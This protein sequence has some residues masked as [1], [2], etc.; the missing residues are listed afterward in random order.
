MIIRLEPTNTEIPDEI[1]VRAWDFGND[2]F[3]KKLPAA[4]QALSEGVTIYVFRAVNNKNIV[5]VKIIKIKTASLVSTPHTGTDYPVSD[6]QI[7]L[8]FNGETWDIDKDKYLYG[9]IDW[10]GPANLQDNIVSSDQSDRIV[11]TWKGPPSRYFPIVDTSKPIAG[12]TYED[13]S[14]LSETIYTPFTS[15]L[16]ASGAVLAI[17]PPVNYP[18]S[19]STVDHQGQILGAAIDKDQVL[20][21]IVKAIYTE[22]EFWW[23]ITDGILPWDYYN[24]YQEAAVA[25]P[26]VPLSSKSIIQHDRPG[27]GYWYE[28]YKATGNPQ[29]VFKTQQDESG[30]EFVTR[31]QA[32]ERPKVPWFFN[33]SATEAQTVESGLVWKFSNNT[34][35]TKDTGNGQ[36]TATGS[37]KEETL[38]DT[39]SV[40]PDG[41][42]GTT[43]PGYHGKSFYAY[44]EFDPDY[45][46][47]IVPYQGKKLEGHSKN[48]EL[49]INKS[50]KRI[51]AVDYK[52]DKE[53]V[54][55]VD[56]VGSSLSQFS[57]I[58]YRSIMGDVQWADIYGPADH[59]PSGRIDYVY[60]DANSTKV[61]DWFKA[62]L[63]NMCRPN[64]TYT[65]SCGVISD[66][67]H[68]LNL[69]TCCAPCTKQL[70]V[71][72]VASSPEGSLNLS[73][74]QQVKMAGTWK[75]SSSVSFSPEGGATGVYLYPLKNGSLSQNNSD[76]AKERIKINSV[77][78]GNTR[79]NSPLCMIEGW[80][81]STYTVKG[82]FERLHY[83]GGNPP[84]I[85][86]CGGSSIASDCPCTGNGLVTGQQLFVNG[87]RVGFYAW[88]PYG[89][90]S[91]CG[92]GRTAYFF[93]C[94]YGNEFCTANVV[95]EYY[96]TDYV[97][98]CEV[99]SC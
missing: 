45:Q 24:T 22:R 97:C 8:G 63:F 75:T 68:I 87:N 3:I 54:A 50:G 30:W 56:I 71:N 36:W 70:V 89:A 91:S 7:A 34:F 40:P 55:T 98:T 82:T 28:V 42:F 18:K 80:H 81:G 23:T 94:G 35:T 44:D 74:T 51:V 37:Y 85:G 88:V 10:L 96:V 47:Y 12:I 38:N 48:G 26:D 93:T 11:L 57:S 73:N 76:C 41:G 99:W 84:A 31:I 17:G 72:V 9:N 69:D 62:V 16:Y 58:D 6:A 4:D 20:W 86:N 1:L 53:V 66:D 95:E 13:T 14:A 78:T 65:S 27:L 21:V 29:G 61:G 15:N 43:T 92:T 59:I 83:W 60:V 90:P 52:G 25:F 64:V 32:K 67:G 39:V 2:V 33:E 46:T 19:D 5:T 49:T 79:K 77:V